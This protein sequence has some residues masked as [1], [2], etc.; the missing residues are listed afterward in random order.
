MRKLKNLKSTYER[1][2]HLQLHGTYYMLHVVFDVF[3][4]CADGTKSRK[5]SHI[6]FAS[7]QKQQK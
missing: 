6:S 5:V 1:V 7:L 2:L 4:N 3:L